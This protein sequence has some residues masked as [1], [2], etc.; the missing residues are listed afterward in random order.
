M[1]QGACAP[2]AAVRSFAANAS[3]ARKRENWTS[4]GSAQHRSHHLTRHH[5]GLRGQTVTRFVQN[6]KESTPER[7]HD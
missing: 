4:R 1:P 2:G 3:P 6:S 5:H 7:A